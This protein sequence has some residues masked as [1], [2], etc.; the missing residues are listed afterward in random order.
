MESSLMQACRAASAD[1]KD[2]MFDEAKLHGLPFDL[3][4]KVGNL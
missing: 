4:F 3:C 1:D 2:T